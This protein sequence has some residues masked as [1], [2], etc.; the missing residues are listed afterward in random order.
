[1]SEVEA[2]PLDLLDR[3]TVRVRARNV[4]IAAVIVAAAFGGIVSLFA[5][6]VGFATTLVIVAVP[7]L[8]LAWTESRKTITLR[9]HEVVA[10]ALGSRVVDVHKATKLELFVTDLRGARTINVLIG[11]APRG[12]AISV[13]LAMYA[14][15]GGRELGVYAL[16]RLA[17]ALAGNE[18]TRGLVLSQL[19]VAQLRA[20]ARGEAPPNRPLYRLASLA[21]QG[22]MAQRLQ[23]EAVSKFVATL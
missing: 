1:M 6:P 16:R 23:P 14:G 13:S 15:T 17:D 22:R 18:D 11:G 7:L 12:K 3:R 5:G 10:R 4:A 8:L 19:V 21:P 2:V 9:G 20:E